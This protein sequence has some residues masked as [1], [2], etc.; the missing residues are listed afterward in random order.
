MDNTLDKVKDI[1]GSPK[2]TDSKPK[3]VIYDGHQFS[4]KI[5][6]EFADLVGMKGGDDFFF[7]IIVPPH[8]KK[9]KKELIGRWKGKE[10]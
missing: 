9:G 2:L 4:V 5:P 1:I 10:S 7:E 3:K 8:D 6:K